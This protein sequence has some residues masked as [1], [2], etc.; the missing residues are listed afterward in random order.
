MT[1][2][3][4]MN[5]SGYAQATVAKGSGKRLDEVSIKPAKGGGFVVVEQYR[6]TSDG[7]ARMSTP[8]W[9]PAE[10]PMAFESFDGMVAALRKCFGVKTKE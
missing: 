7:K 1:P 5:D 2:K 3:A 6:R 8:D 9:L 4:T 10:P